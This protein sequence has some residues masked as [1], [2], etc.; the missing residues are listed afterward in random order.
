M[1]CTWENPTSSQVTFGESANDDTI[2]GGYAFCCPGD[3]ICS[4]LP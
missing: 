4:M 2:N 1:S 3:P